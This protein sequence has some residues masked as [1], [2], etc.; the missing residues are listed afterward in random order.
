MYIVCVYIPV[1]EIGG[2]LLAKF[3]TAVRHHCRMSRDRT[4]SPGERHGVR[5]CGLG[6]SR[7]EGPSGRRKRKVAGEGE[8]GVE[9]GEIRIMYSVYKQVLWYVCGWRDG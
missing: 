2:F 7:Q 9:R 3:Y 6:Q 1:D 5:T 4:V 8:R